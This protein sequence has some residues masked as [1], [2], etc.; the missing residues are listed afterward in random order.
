M[1][2]G[3]S[4]CHESQLWA[5]AA[6]MDASLLGDCIPHVQHRRENPPIEVTE[7]IRSWDELSECTA[8]G[9]EDRLL[10]WDELSVCTEEETETRSTDIWHADV[11]VFGADIVAL[12][13]TVLRAFQHIEYQTT[14]AR[15]KHATLTKLHE[16]TGYSSEAVNNHGARE[17]CK[18]ASIKRCIVRTVCKTAI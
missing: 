17:V 7:C 9:N 12:A 18:Y 6:S 10:A 4:Q 8:A 1:S 3:Q 13:S 5:A 2:A 11:R 14:Q 15:V 16:S